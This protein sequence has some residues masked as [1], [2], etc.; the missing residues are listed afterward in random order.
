MEFQDV[1]RRRRMVRDYADRPVAREQVGD[2]LVAVVI[3]GDVGA[4]NKVWQTLIT[5]AGRAMVGRVAL[6]DGLSGEV[7]SVKLPRDPACPVCGA[8]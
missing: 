7:R 6:I 8:G 3:K 2:G 1:V 4:V 5:G